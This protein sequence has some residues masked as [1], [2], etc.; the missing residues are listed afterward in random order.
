MSGSMGK[1]GQPW[2]IVG[3][4]LYKNIFLEVS[5]EAETAETAASLAALREE[6]LCLI[7]RAPHITRGYVA[8]QALENGWLRYDE[9]TPAAAGAYI[10]L[11]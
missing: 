11:S 4:L 7:R 9:H 3:H 8:E 6:I 10:Y 5:E 2:S 1:K